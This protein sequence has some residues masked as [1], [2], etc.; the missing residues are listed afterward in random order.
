MT[1]VI[2]RRTSAAARV[3][4]PRMSRTGVTSSI[5]TALYAASSGE[6]N[7]SLYSSVK[8][9][10][11]VSQLASLVMAEFQKTV[12]TA[13]RRGTARRVYGTHSSKA[14]I[15]AIE[16]Q[17]DFKVDVAEVIRRS[18]RVVMVCRYSCL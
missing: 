18:N 10:I 13:S 6:S 15:R 14:T 17:Q 9:S 16:H 2:P 1:Q 4:S 3:P 5:V 8:S 7:G 12:A 11:A